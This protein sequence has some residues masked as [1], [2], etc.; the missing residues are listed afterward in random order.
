[1][2]QIILDTETTGFRPG[3]IVSLAAI[4]MVDGELT[5][6]FAHYHINPKMPCDPG[7]TKVHGLTDEYLATCPTF[8]NVI[9]PLD[10][11]L[12][13]SPIIAHNAP[14]DMGF[15]EAEYRRE[16]E[17]SGFAWRVV[18]PVRCTYSKAEVQRGRAKGRNTLDA[19]TE[20]YKVQ[21]FRGDGRHGALVDALTLFSVYRALWGADPLPLVQ[22]QLDHFL[23]KGFGV[24]GR[25]EFTSPGSPDVPASAQADPSPVRPDVCAIR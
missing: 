9:G 21:N 18:N 6:A 25:F 17:A 20:A 15:L 8:S 10:T 23:N 24:H 14:F 16:S 13:A 7:A 4:E 2:R 5:G 22:S 19:L 11:F 3:G 12:G 1:V